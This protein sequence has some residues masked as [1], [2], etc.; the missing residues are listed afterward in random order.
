MPKFRKK[1]I[2][3]D[4]VRIKEGVAISTREG[5]L[6]GYPGDWLITGIE[7]EEY[8]CDDTIFRQT[9]EPADPQAEELM[10]ID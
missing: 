7:G 1:S 3:I 10:T 2:V 6:I 4:A 9:Y 5:T 8:P